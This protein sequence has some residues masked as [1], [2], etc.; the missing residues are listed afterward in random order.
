MV[1]AHTTRFACAVLLVLAGCGGGLYLELG[2]GFDDRSPNVSL[3]VS[4]G[5]AAP[6]QSVRLVAAAADDF[7]IS[8]VAFLRR[9]AGGSV[10]LGTD[11]CSPYELDTQIPLGAAGSV[12]FFARAT[13]NRGFVTQSEAVSVTVVP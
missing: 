7:G 9:D 1:A 4:P 11:C 13:D 6:G 12:Q 5:S 2:D 8:Q 10:T 3:A